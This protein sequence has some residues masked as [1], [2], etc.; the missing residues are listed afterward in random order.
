[1]D[2]SADTYCRRSKKSEWSRNPL[3]GECRIGDLTTAEAMQYL[4][5]KRQIDLACNCASKILEFCGTRILRLRNS[6][7][8]LAAG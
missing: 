4:T 1:M 8:K 3:D 5:E 7:N 2:V 6:C